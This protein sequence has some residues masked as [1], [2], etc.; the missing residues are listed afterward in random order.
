MT[1]FLPS[2]RKF[3]LAVVLMS[4][5]LAAQSGLGIVTGTV[6]DPSKGTIAK[7]GITLTEK[8]TGIVRKA[9]T[10]GAGIYYFGSIPVGPYHLVVEATGFKEWSSDFQLE[11]GQTIT[12]NP[13][14]S[15]G[16]VQAKVD[17]ST[18]APLITT[19]GSQLSDEKTAQ[20]I[21]DLP[22]NGRQI[23]NLFTL[24]PGVEGGQNTQGGAAPRTNGM[25]VGSTEILLDGLSSVDRF[26][27][28]MTRVQPGLDTIQEYRIET[29]G[30]GAA[31]DRPSTIEL[32]TRSG[33]NQFHGGLFETLR[34]NYGGLVA[35]AV[36]DGNTPAKLIR[37]EF[38]GFIGGPIVKNKAFFF[39][40][41]EL[42][43]QSSQVY[44]QI[45]VP[46]AAMWGG[47][48]SNAVDTSGNKINIYN[49]YST[50]SSGGRAV[51]AGNQIPTSML[52]SQLTN[53][54]KSVTPLPSGPNASANP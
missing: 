22:L 23:T 39:Y 3:L 47:D 27:G 17:V 12:V 32:V 16:D 41:Q 30:S 48:F 2:V 20:T 50:T 46:T 53:A 26:G 10:N 31:F 51:F 33:T 4:L 14:V 19:E 6:Q 8:A 25:M 37:N 21:H 49:P 45:A 24:T 44:N 11:A 1:S 54:F 29:S 7:A 13:A 42:L 52:N 34:D 15:V 40:D 36:Q 28:G 43:R 35:R 38:G 5:P 9:V 18:A